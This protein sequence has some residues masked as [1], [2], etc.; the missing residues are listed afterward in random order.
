MKVVTRSFLDQFDD[1]DL[2]WYACYGS[3]INTERF[4]HYINGDKT[5]KLSSKDGCKDK[6]LPLEARAYTFKCPIYFAGESRR[7]TG[8]MAFLDY[9][10]EGE[11]YGKIYKIKMNQFIGVLEQEQKCRLYDAII[12]VDTIDGAPIFSF[13]SLHKLNDRLNKPSNRYIETIKSGILDTYPDLDAKKLE[14]YFE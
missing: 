13:T 5:G 3:N 4:M 1:E 12:M 8:G 6:S 9:E 14:H 2:V 7:W 11:S 10:A